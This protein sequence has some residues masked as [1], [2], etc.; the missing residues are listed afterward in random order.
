MR[1]GSFET[2]ERVLLVAE[3]GNNH[4]GDVSVARELV[5]EAARCGADAVKFQTFRTE[6]FVSRAD[7]DRFRRLEGFRFTEDQFAE[8]A[9]LAHAS[10]LLFVSTPLDLESARF[11]VEIA[12]GGKVASGDNDFHA[13]LDVLARS[14][15]PLIVSTGLSDLTLLERTTAFVED[16][17]R[18]RTDLGLL[19]C[20]SAY[21]APNAEVNLRAIATLAAHFPGWTIGYSDHALGVDAAVLAVAAGARIV[22]K[23]FTLDKDFSDFRDHQLSADPAALRDLAHRIRAAEELLGSPGKIVQPS[24]AEGTTAYRRSA[25]AAHNLPVGH[26]IEPG[27]LTWLRPGDGLRADQD[28]SLRGRAL[29]RHVTRGERLRPDD[30]AGG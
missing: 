16:A 30:V 25:V 9:E 22:E 7:E 14:D 3:I 12:D 8:L 19:H 20:T 15:K 2:D 21:P 23:H 6:L 10:G 27:D 26:V 5:E 11:L 24:E 29:R 18:S 17:R 13:L 4:E 1:I 28:A